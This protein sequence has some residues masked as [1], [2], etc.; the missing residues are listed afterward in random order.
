M[1]YTI[2][3][4]VIGFA[5]LMAVGCDS[6]KPAQEPSDRAMQDPMNYRPGFDDS[7]ISGG[8]ITDF[9]KKAFR[10]DVDSV[11]NP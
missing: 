4:A 11:L 1:R 8:G 9:D 6:G 2:A 10:K 5:A 7:N 3:L